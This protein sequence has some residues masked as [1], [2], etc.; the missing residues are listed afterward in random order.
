MPRK[1]ARVLLA[2]AMLAVV[3]ASGPAVASGE[4]SVQTVLGSGMVSGHIDGGAWS[5]QGWTFSGLNA[6]DRLSLVVFTDV[7]GADATFCVWEPDWILDD[8]PFHSSDWWY[9]GHRFTPA[10]PDMAIA[11][12]V[13]PPG[14]GGDYSVYV[15]GYDATDFDLYWMRDDDIVQRLWGETR[16]GTAQSVSRSSFAEA[17]VAVLCSGTSFAD[18]LSA[19]ALAGAYDSPVILTPPGYL[20]TDANVEIMRMNAQRVVIVG[21]T[22]AVSDT[23]EDDLVAMG[24]DQPGDIER[25]AGVDRYQT[26]AQVADKVIALTAGGY[27]HAFVVNGANF[28]D[29]LAVSPYAHNMKYPVLLT[30]PSSLHAE[31]AAVIDFYNF[32]NVHVAGGTGA[33]SATAYQQI[34]ALN[35]GTTVVNRMSGANRYQTAVAVAD[36]AND[37][38][39]GTYANV[40]LATGASFPDALGAGPAIGQRGGVLLLQSPA[41]DTGAELSASPAGLE[42]AMDSHGPTVEHLLLI[43]GMGAVPIGAEEFYWSEFDAL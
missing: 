33:V 3:A 14:G 25:I 10:V 1:T 13:V 21:G 38:G 2:G 31:A 29:A 35:G 36:Y 23:V 20:G 6:G 19:S 15:G 39:W 28:P 8:Q 4:P 40:A 24:Y 16:Y 42:L 18:A 37:H 12:Y 41:D 9:A 26:S 32:S 22:A 17:G 43:G 7:D 11:D 27:G 30:P 34:D 5:S